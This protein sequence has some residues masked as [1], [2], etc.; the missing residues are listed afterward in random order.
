M[1][2]HVPRR[3]PSKVAIIGG[4]ISGMGAAYKLAETHNV[5]LFEAE[6]DLGGHA[7]TRMGGRDGD[8]SVDT[9]FIVF[10]HVNYPHLVELFRELEV[11]TV[12]SDMSFGASLG[13]GRYEYALKSL[14]AIFAQ[15]MNAL[16]P[17]H[18]RMVR[19]IMHFNANALDV[20][21]SDR[22]MTVEEMLKK[23]G[24]GEWFRNRYLL[25][26]SGAI[27]STPVEKIADFPAYAM[28]QF[29]E[30]HAL[31][32]H[33]GQHQWYTVASGS[34]SYVS[35]LENRLNLNNVDLRLGAWV[36]GMRRTGAGAE[37]RVH[38][39]EW[40]HFDEVIFATHSDDSLR[41]LADPTAAEQ[42]ALG[43]IK[44]QP[45][46]VVLHSDAD[47]MPKRRVVWSSWNYTE[48]HGKQTD[49]IDLTYW[50]NNLQPWLKKDELFVTLNSTRTIREELI[51]DEVTLRHPVYDLAALEGQKQVAAINGQN[52]TWFCGAWMKNGF[53]ED[54]LSSAIDVVNA[55][56]SAQEFSVAAE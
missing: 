50:M 6:K 2:V 8:Q 42:E 24:T 29:F 10:N 46:R 43:S 25:P 5:T 14:R 45:N 16:N 51:W 20:A 34:R 26:L 36:E 21:R 44:Y 32:H 22:T 9:G 15:P 19:D 54:G 4:G 49:Q 3:I 48:M 12:K 56:Q 38:G 47:I 23:L 52:R 30:N 33:T 13:D 11:P 27:W 28:M 37:V 39:G 17:K 18:L 55:L 7:R 35:R 31:L 53:H 1:N 40:E 41:L